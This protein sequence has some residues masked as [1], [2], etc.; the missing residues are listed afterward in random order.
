MAKIS[1]TLELER[2]KKLKDEGAL[3][4]FEYEKLKHDILFGS[5][6][7]EDNI[8]EP[9][10][11]PETAQTD[12]SDSTPP[13]EEDIQS[14]KFNSTVVGFIIAVVVVVI[15]AIIFLTL[16]RGKDESP[17]V[18]VAASET[19]RQV[20]DV[21]VPDSE[22]AKK[23]LLNDISGAWSD[24]KAMVYIVYQDNKFQVWL[25]TDLLA[26]SLG[27][28]DAE[29]GTVNVVSTDPETKIEVI[30]TVKKIWNTDKT[31]YKLE[32][33]GNNGERYKLDFVRKISND[34]LNRLAKL[35]ADIEKK[36]KQGGEVTNSEAR[37]IAHQYVSDALN[38]SSAETL[39][40][41]YADTV[42]YY[43][44]GAISRDTVLVEKAAYYKE[45][46]QRQETLV[47]DVIISDSKDGLKMASFTYRYVLANDNKQ[48]T[49]TATKAVVFKKINGDIFIA[50]ENG[51]TISSERRDLN[52][53][54]PQSVPD[55]QQPVYRP[56]QQQPRSDDDS[57]DY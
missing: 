45:W 10:Q 1:K 22:E 23:A 6:D 21:V 39:R 7:E 24:G 14:R 42:N 41:Y 15:G 38:A 48:I 8:A 50:A 29:H 20:S 57:S 25:G 52:S 26:A 11:T 32:L 47:G 28:V 12:K 9:H 49:G 33:V 19:Q 3:S 43:S 13:A 34:D 17:P 16:S 27:N 5:D 36:N 35:M 51:K 55:E 30:S 54:P 2:L 40:S 18:A 56:V 31:S 4:D 53:E 44:K 46:P 37:Q